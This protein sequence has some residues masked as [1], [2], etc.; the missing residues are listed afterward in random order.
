MLLV[1]QKAANDTL[2]ERVPGALG[3]GLAGALIGTGS[4]IFGI[5]GGS[6]TVPFLSWCRLK[7]QQAVAISSACGLPI[8]VAGTV[9]FAI[10]GWDE[11][12]LPDGAL[13]YVF[14]PATAGIVLTSFPFAR[15]AARVSHRLPSVTLKRVFAV[16]LFLLG[17]KLFFG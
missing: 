13:G 4:A 2:P 7:M 12:R 16:V 6:L 17:L 9:G 15:L 3:L 8:A 14:L 11:S 5:G 1:G 10:A